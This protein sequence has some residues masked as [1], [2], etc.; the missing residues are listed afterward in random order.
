MAEE[1]FGCS[2][3]RGSTKDDHRQL[4]P[5]GSQYSLLTNHIKVSLEG[6]KPKDLIVPRSVRNPR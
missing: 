2:P 4:N 3:S 1:Q 5:S 6:S